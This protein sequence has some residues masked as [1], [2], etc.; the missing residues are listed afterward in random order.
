[1]ME[2]TQILTLIKQKLTQANHQITSYDLIPDEPQE[3]EKTIVNLAK[4]DSLQAIIMTGGTGISPRDNTPDVV[5]KLIEKELKGF[6]E[7]FRLLSYQEIGSKAILSR[8]MAGVYQK[9]VIFALP[10]SKNA[11]TLALDKLI[12]PEISH[13]VTQLNPK[14]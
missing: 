6:G 2:H 8:A 14:L 1:M 9:K 3:I 12:I 10:G 11:V 13:L 5:S 4:N 7:I